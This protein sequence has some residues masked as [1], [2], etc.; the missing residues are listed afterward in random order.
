[1]RL[2]HLRQLALNLRFRTKL[3]L[4]LFLILAITT[5]I[6]FATYIRQN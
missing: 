1:M 3:A 5:A 4:I 6:L 2:P